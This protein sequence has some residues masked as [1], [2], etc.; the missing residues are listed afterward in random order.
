MRAFYIPLISSIFISVVLG[1]TSRFNLD[2]TWEIRAPDGFER[3]VILV[4][5]QFPGPTL[6]IRQ[7][8]QVEITVRNYLPFSTTLHA[9]GI[10]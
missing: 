6:N 3:R 1:G 8:D 10:Q 7:G 5:N 2:L 4:N 9:H